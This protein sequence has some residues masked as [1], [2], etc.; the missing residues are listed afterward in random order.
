MNVGDIK[1]VR[2]SLGITKQG[3]AKLSG[4][5]QALIARIESGSVDPSYS[6]TMK[7]FAV[8]ESRKHSG[9]AND[10]MTKKV[11]SVRSSEKISKAIKIMKRKGISQLPV[12]DD[13][14]V[15]GIVSEKEVSHSFLEK[16]FIIKEIMSE[17]PPIVGKSAPVDLLACLL[18]FHPAVLVQESGSPCGI[19]TRADI[20][21]LIKKH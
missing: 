18:D 1:T 10:I 13:S 15:I 21:K 8:L 9:S 20:M 19:V 2:K 3:L 4:V 11:V 6:G 5:S 16:K 17:S 12:I 7:I 14:K